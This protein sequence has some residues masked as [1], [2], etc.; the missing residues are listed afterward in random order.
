MILNKIYS[1]QQLTLTDIRL[2]LIMFFKIKEQKVKESSIDM[3]IKYMT[4]LNEHPFIEEFNRFRPLNQIIQDELI[5]TIENYIEVMKIYK[6][7]EFIKFT[8]NEDK[9]Q[10]LSK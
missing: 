10:K 3:F 5:P 6:N 8:F 4:K 7:N 1:E 9:Y 2:M